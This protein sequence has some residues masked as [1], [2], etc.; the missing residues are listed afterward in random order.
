MFKVK[1]Q[2]DVQGGAVTFDD[3]ASFVNLAV[4]EGCF[5]HKYFICKNSRCVYILCKVTP[6]VYSAFASFGANFYSK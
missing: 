3:N 5:Y 2:C 6:Q 4:V 1:R